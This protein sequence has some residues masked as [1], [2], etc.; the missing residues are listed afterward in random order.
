MVSQRKLDAETASYEGSLDLR[1]EIEKGV[2]AHLELLFDLFA[3][4]LKNVHGD[5]GFVAVFQRD[6]RVTDLR[7]FVF[8]KK[9]HSIDQCQVC[10]RC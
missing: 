3:A 2:E 5:V 4:A 1:V 9:S 10:H 7:D 8:G 6:G